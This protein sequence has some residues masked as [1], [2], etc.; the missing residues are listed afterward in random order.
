LVPEPLHEQELSGTKY[1][2]PGLFWGQLALQSEHAAWACL[3]ATPASLLLR[4][5]LFLK[6]ALLLVSSAASI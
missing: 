4:P 1:C 2:F 5:L 3:A 6:A